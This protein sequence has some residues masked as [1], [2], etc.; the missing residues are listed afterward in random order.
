M[1]T[2]EGYSSKGQTERPLGIMTVSSIDTMAPVRLKLVTLA[3]FMGSSQAFAS[4]LG[5]GGGGGSNWPQRA[6]PPTHRH[7]REKMKFDCLQ[8]GTSGKAI[9]V[10]LN[11]VRNSNFRALGNLGNF[12]GAHGLGYMGLAATAGVPLGAQLPTLSPNDHPNPSKGRQKSGIGSG[13]IFEKFSTQ[14][15]RRSSGIISPHP[16]P[17]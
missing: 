12:R 5:G 15:I 2:E 10:P 3:G 17:K 8:Q 4:D 1:G 13:G 6:D 9:Q 11:S 16:I 7:P 14:V